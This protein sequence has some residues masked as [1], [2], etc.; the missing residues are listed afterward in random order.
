MNV[1]PQ[2]WVYYPEFYKGAEIV[3]STLFWT[4]VYNCVILIPLPKYKPFKDSN[5][6]AVLVRDKEILDTYN[7]IVSYIHGLLCIGLVYYDTTYSNLPCGSPNTKVQNFTM[8]MSLG[9]FLYDSVALAYYKLLDYP[10]AAHHL[11]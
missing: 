4:V 5:G 7:R 2:N 3:A 8:V 11:A 10:M 1:P 6:K 9:Y